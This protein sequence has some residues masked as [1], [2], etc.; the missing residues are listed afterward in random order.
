MT[1]DN[2]GSEFFRKKSEHNRCVRNGNKKFYCSKKCSVEATKADIRNCL[3][4]GKETRNPKFCS[5]SCSVSHNDRLRP[6]K[7]KTYDKCAECGKD[8]QKRRR[9]CDDHRPPKK[10]G[11]SLGVDNVK[12]KSVGSLRLN[13][14]GDQYPSI[15]AHARTRAKRLKIL[16]RCIVCGYVNHVEC[17]HKRAISDFPDNTL[18]DEVNSPNNLIGLCPNHHWE[19]DHGMLNL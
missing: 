4:C 18:I 11:S 17:C 5:V 2:C 8:V 16:D 13:R 12:Y 9:Y 7:T 1:C 3:F 10:P 6:K 15:R 19:F 14:T